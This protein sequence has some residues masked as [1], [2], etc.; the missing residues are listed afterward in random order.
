MHDHFE[1][2]NVFINVHYTLLSLNYWLNSLLTG[3]RLNRRVFTKVKED[4]D[5]LTDL[6]EYSNGFLWKVK[7]SSPKSKRFTIHALD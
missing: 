2:L 4:V 5:Y 6:E 1:F 7:Y 3:A